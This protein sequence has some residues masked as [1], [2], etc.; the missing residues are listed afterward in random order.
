M[1]SCSTVV[2]LQ[3][4]FLISHSDFTCK[5]VAPSQL[6]NLR[7]LNPQF[8][9]HIQKEHCPI[10][11]SLTFYHD[12]NARAPQNVFSCDTVLNCSRYISKIRSVTYHNPKSF[13]PKTKN[14]INHPSHTMTC[15]QK[16]THTENLKVVSECLLKSTISLAE[17]T[18]VLGNF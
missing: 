15:S 1:S 14:G 18:W 7:L 6:L 10:K 12:C 3:G 2:S 17:P 11:D 4:I 5:M 16:H 9:C 13:P 8:S